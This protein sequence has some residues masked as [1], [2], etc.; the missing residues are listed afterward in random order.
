MQQDFCS[1]ESLYIRA[2]FRLSPFSEYETI[3]AFSTDSPP[4]RQSPGNALAVGAQGPIRILRLVE[5]RLELVQ[6]RDE[7]GVGD[8]RLGLDHQGADNVQVLYHPKDL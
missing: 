7:P 5:Q 6:T 2:G 4:F 3:S 1:A 8:G